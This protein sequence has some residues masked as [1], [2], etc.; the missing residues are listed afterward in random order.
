MITTTGFH[1]VK[2]AGKHPSSRDAAWYDERQR[3][4]H[5]ER[6]TPAKKMN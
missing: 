1:D 6:D 5:A 4:Y 3:F 2:C